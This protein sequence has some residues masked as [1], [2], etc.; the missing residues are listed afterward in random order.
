MRFPNLFSLAPCFRD[1]Y[2][3]PCHLV[4][5]VEQ[6]FNPVT[7]IYGYYVLLQNDE[8]NLFELFFT[9]KLKNVEN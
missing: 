1:Q 8:C 6:F 9:L 2:R 4:K 3:I 7:R 5:F